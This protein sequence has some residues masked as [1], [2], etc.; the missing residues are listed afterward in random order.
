[1]GVWVTKT[2]S[3]LLFIK[4]PKITGQYC[5]RPRNSFM[6][7]WGHFF[8]N[9]A[10]LRSEVVLLHLHLVAVLLKSKYEGQQTCQ[11]K[12]RK[13]S[14]V[15]ENKILYSKCRPDTY[16]PD[17]MWETHSELEM[18]TKLMEHNKQTSVAAVFECCLICWINWWELKPISA[19]KNG[20][21]L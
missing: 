17:W 2:H 8:R 20:A 21:S 19:N 14:L 1:M 15:S 6:A 18:D 4:W 3:I 5:Y 7:R 9:E 10:S 11:S 13:P 12:R 16:A